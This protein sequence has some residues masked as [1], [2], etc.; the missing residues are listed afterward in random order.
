M[1]VGLAF[2]SFAGG[3]VSKWLDWRG[4]LTLAAAGTLLV[5]AG[6]A[7]VPATAPEIRRTSR[8]VGHAENRGTTVRKLVRPALLGAG[9]ATVGGSIV[10]CVA[11][12]PTYLHEEFSL[13]TESAGTLTGVVSLVGVVGGFLAS[14][15]LVRG[16][17][18]KRLFLVMLLMPAGASAA[19]GG[20][21]GLG[22]SVGSALV[23]A[24]ANELVV[25]TVFAAEPL[26]VQAASDLGAANGLVAQLGSVGT[27][28]TPPLVGV[29]VTTQRTVG[30][31]W[32]RVCW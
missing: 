16:I 20:P 30:G 12:Y 24:L 32:G 4:W 13:S 11:L 28:A 7:R 31:P 9:F 1:P 6:A 2:G 10:T 14:W 26:A 23:I 27:L 8:H 19:F 18:V 21:G 5:A 22:G 15:L 25:A 3:V 29:V 17:G